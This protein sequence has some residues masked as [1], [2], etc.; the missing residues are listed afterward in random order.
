MNRPA[1]LIAALLTLATMLFAQL[2]VAAHPC[3]AVAN[4]I[5]AE[6]MATDDAPPCHGQNR[7]KTASTALCKLHCTDHHRTVVDAFAELPVAF[8]ATF[9]VPL[10]VAEETSNGLQFTP[11]IGLSHAL[12]PPLAITHCCL[13]I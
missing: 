9:A 7:A 2:A 10:M 3:P 11:A 12:G 1:R 13:R 8:I 6:T 4:A 5:A